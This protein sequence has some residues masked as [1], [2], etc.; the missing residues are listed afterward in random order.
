MAKTLGAIGIV[1]ALFGVVVGLTAPIVCLVYQ[2]G[3]FA[4]PDDPV[5]PFGCGTT[6]GA[7]NEP[8]MRKLYEKCGKWVGDYWWCGWRNRA[9]GLA[10]ELK[11]DHFV[12]MTSYDNVVVNKKEYGPLRVIIVDEYREFTLS[13]G[14][15]HIIAGYRL[16]PIYDEHLNNKLNNAQIPYRPINMDAR[17]IISVRFGGK[18]D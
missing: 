16:R 18:D 14:I 11:P 3:W 1:K 17:P 5:S 7:S 2:R 10:Y 13:L 6:P 4:T 9:L 8:F 15:A 12:Q